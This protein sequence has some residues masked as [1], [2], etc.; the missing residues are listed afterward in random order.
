MRMR[1]EP[2]DDDFEAARDVLVGRL[3][4][5][6]GQVQGSGAVDTF[7]VA[8]ALDY[9]HGATVDGRLGLW[10]S[11]HV[12][13][14]LLDWAPRT[15]TVLPG[16]ALP[17]APGALRL[18]LRYLDAT[19][20]ADPR[21]A[22]LDTLLG[23][24]DD[25]AA[26]YPRAMADRT[27][28][29]LAKF[30]TTLAAEQGVDLDSPAA[31]DRFTERARRGE[32]PYDEDVLQAIAARHMT[33]GPPGA[34]RAEPQLP[35]TL[36]PPETLKAEAGR[37]PLLGVLKGLAAWAGREG[38]PV[39]ATG[40]LKTADA[41]ELTERLGTGDTPPAAVRSVDD[42]PRLRLVFELAKAA[43]LA[44]VAKGRL[45][46]VGKA[47]G[48][49]KDPLALWRRAFDA[50]FGMR[51]P[52]L[53]AKSGWH[54]ESMLFDA[55]EDILPDVLNTL[56][57]LPHPMPWPR[58]RDS[59]DHAYR[60]R[61]QL[62]GA[63]HRMWFDD[64]HRDLRLVL[65]LLE[66]LG[67]VER[68]V[69]LADP[70]Y[71]S[72]QLPTGAAPAGR[73]TGPKADAGEPSDGPVELIRLTALGTW[74]VRARLLDAGRDAP[75][76]GELAHAPA[77]GLLGTLAEHYDTDAARLELDRWIQAHDGPQQA[78]PLLLD[79]I[80]TMPYRTRGQAMLEALSAALPE[81]EGDRFVLPLRSDPQL[82][83]LAIGVLVSRGRLAPEDLT[84]GESLVMV[85]EG[86]IQYLEVTGPDGF[87]DALLAQGADL[88]EAL[89]VALAAPHPDH[90]ALQDLRN[91]A[92]R[93]PRTPVARAGRRAGTPARPARGGKPGGGRRR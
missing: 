47:A 4:R 28:W 19:G 46:T 34:L 16:E 48:D 74:A 89:D 64:A 24:V 88:R 44:R 42:L 26:G 25:T 77:A 67:A 84:E 7:A 5:W 22:D 60:V 61:F 65:D 40:R 66:E 31:L 75:L 93:M 79:A 80:R 82:A 2:D 70:V 32:V 41:R 69:G 37:V 27:R 73:T 9:R 87:G 11:R 86:M 51:R 85:A 12:Q 38:R 92:A 49:L 23:A 10:E 76:V 52:L 81:G 43:R 71:R 15:L 56:Y 39:T 50:V 72:L 13:A 62:G 20:L 36:P 35:V 78:L 6:A 30:W 18:L 29:G 17:E 57:S 55:Y 21:G 91:A 90:A 45:Y 83:P 58:L 63:A 1:Y 33:E 3:E 8:A 59:V 68:Q 54:T 53:G 14:F